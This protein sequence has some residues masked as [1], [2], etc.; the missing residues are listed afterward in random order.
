MLDAGAGRYN[1]ISGDA[2]L[3]QFHRL[4]EPRTELPVFCRYTGKQSLTIRLGTSGEGLGYVYVEGSE[5]PPQLMTAGGEDV[6]VLFKDWVEY[7]EM[8][9][10][11]VNSDP[12]SPDYFD[13]DPYF[14]ELPSLI[15]ERLGVQVVL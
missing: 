9:Q 15:S 5:Q 2:A 12:R 1:V 13:S 11:F 3:E 8:R 14:E 6:G 7:I 4:P 10:S